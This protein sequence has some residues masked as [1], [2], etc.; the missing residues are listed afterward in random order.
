MV[1]HYFVI[2][3]HVLD[4]KEDSLILQPKNRNWG[5]SSQKNVRAFQDLV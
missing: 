1:I 3:I 2:E 5:Q 4:L